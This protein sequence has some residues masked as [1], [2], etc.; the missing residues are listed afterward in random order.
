M[1]LRHPHVD[2]AVVVD[3]TA[4][5]RVQLQE[6]LGTR[7]SCR[8]NCIRLPHDDVPRPGLD[9]QLPRCSHHCCRD[10]QLLLLSLSHLVS[11][12]TGNWTGSL[13]SKIVT[14]TRVGDIKFLQGRVW[15]GG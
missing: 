2:S 6:K 14:K 7:I 12:L 9:R 10:H 8:R 13:W 1:P 4:G 15:V 3:Q 5:Q 11:G